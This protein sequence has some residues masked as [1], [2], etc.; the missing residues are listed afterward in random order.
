MMDPLQKIRQ[1]DLK[2]AYLDTQQLADIDSL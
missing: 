2:Q 1:R